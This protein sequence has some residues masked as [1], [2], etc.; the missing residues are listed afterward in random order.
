MTETTG[1]VGSFFS[2]QSLC[3]QCAFCTAPT[4]LL[5]FYE[6][7]QRVLDCRHLLCAFIA[8]SRVLSLSLVLSV[9]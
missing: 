3:E 4:V 6:N 8:L 1:T 9:P 7:K 2:V 5:S